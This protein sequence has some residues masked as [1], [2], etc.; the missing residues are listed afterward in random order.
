VAEPTVISYGNSTFSDAGNTT[1]TVAG[2]SWQAGDIVLVLAG[3]SNNTAAG[4]I[5]TPTV[6]GL[7]GTG[8]TFGS[9]ATVNDNGSN[10]DAQVY[11]WSAT[12][13]GT[14]SGT[15]SSTSTT[16]SGERN[17]IGVFVYRGSDGL[18]TPVTLDG[19]SAKTISVTRVQANSHVVVILIDWNQVGD[20]TVTATPTGTV[21]FAEAESGQADFFIVSFG[22]QGATGTTAYGI[23]NHTGTVD[24]SGIAVEVK[25]TAGGGGGATLRKNSLMRLG[26]GR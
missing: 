5:G 8:L 25:G 16:P 23:T 12:A 24:M 18:G 2:V 17:G 6:T 4:R 22:D 14:G 15:I 21:R 1:N 13:A 7:T 3:N 11:G 9:I 26:V 20:V 10:D 19:S